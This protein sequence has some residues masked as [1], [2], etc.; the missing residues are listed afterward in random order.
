MSALRCAPGA[1]RALAL[2]DW[3]LGYSVAWL[4][5]AGVG[6]IL[7]GLYGVM[8]LLTPGPG[9]VA[10]HFASYMLATALVISPAFS[11]I[12]LALSLPLVIWLM[13]RGRFGWLS[14]LACGLLTG[15]VAAAIMGGLGSFVAGGFGMMAA[16]TLWAVLWLRRPDLF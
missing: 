4:A 11:W 10:L 13:G 1:H 5:P 14:A 6:L 8:A 2:R 7:A 3:I 16:L 12:G 15:E 9:W